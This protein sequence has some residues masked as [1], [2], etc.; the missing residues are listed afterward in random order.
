MVRIVNATLAPRTP[1]LTPSQ[2]R[3]AHRRIARSTAKNPLRRVHL[4]CEL[5]AQRDPLAQVGDR[6][7]CSTHQ[8]FAVVVRVV[9]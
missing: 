5:N 3:A 7:W 4:D 1:E 6:V 9:E 8:E 2:A